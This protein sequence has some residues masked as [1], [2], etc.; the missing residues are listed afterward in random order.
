MKISGNDEIAKYI[1]ETAVTRTKGTAE[2]APAPSDVPKEPKDD[3]VVNLSQMSKEVQLATKAMESEPD[4][5][6]EKVQAIKDRIENGTYE[7]DCGK[8]A[9]KMLKAYFD[10]II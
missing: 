10:E 9:E 3:A 7:I 5:R 1:N 8:T 2:K 6:L 4:V